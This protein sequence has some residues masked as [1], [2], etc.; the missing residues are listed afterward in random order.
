MATASLAISLQRIA[1][2]V[3]E[4]RHMLNGRQ[5]SVALLKR[6][7]EQILRHEQTG[8]ETIRFHFIRIGRAATAKPPP[9]LHRPGDGT[10]PHALSG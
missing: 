4:A 9:Q 10:I 5:I 6:G 7:L 1:V 3:M 8:G 2:A